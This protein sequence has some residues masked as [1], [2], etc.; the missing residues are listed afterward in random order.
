MRAIELEASHGFF[1]VHCLWLFSELGGKSILIA[2][3]ASLHLPLAQV[4]DVLA[5]V[6]RLLAAEEATFGLVGGWEITI[7][8]DFRVRQFVGGGRVCKLFWRI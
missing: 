2:S 7:G 3:F 4:T 6:A 8:A 1:P 5:S